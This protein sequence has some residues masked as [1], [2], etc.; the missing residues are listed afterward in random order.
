MNIKRIIDKNGKL[1]LYIVLIITFVLFAI[2]SLN[3]YY[4]NDE[5]RRKTEETLTERVRIKADLEAKIYKEEQESLRMLKEYDVDIKR[6]AEE[7]ERR[8][9]EMNENIERAKNSHEERMLILKQNHEERMRILTYIGQ[10]ID[11][12]LKQYSYYNDYNNL[13]IE[14][15][16]IINIDLLNSLSTNVYNLLTLVDNQKQDDLLEL[17]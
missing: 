1:I 2:K 13:N 3:A 16:P 4:E 12:G 8:R 6:L 11:L 10:I 14:R 15:S 17:E 9:I 7:T 5:E